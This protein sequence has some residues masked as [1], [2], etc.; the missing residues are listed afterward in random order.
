MGT[1]TYLVLEAFCMRKS[2]NAI[3]RSKYLYE[4]NQDK[5]GRTEYDKNGDFKT[6]KTLNKDYVPGL[7][8]PRKPS[9]CPG[10]ACMECWE[11]KCKF[12][13]LTPASEKA[14]EWMNKNFLE[15]DDD[16]ETETRVER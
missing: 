7:K 6:T 5:N 11:K 8:I 14:D 13:G 1:W 12:L 3:E 9:Y 2:L 15:E 16:D 4:F 10:N